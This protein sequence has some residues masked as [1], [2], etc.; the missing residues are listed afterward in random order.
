M[1]GLGVA[2]REFQL[3]TG[4]ADYGLYIDGKVAGVIEAK[5][6]G[7]TLTGVETQTDKYAKGLPDGV[8]HY[9][10]PLTRQSRHRFRQAL[11]THRRSRLAGPSRDRHRVAIATSRPKSRREILSGREPQRRQSV[12]KHLQ[13]KSLLLMERV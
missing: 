3:T 11:Q 1:A 4:E 13:S 10:L 5:K 8:P 9:G 12:I 2:V 6:T 7:S